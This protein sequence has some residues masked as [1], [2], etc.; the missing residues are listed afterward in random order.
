[1][2]RWLRVSRKAPCVSGVTLDARAFGRLG[3][4]AGVFSRVPRIDLRSGHF[5]SVVEGEGFFRQSDDVPPTVAEA[6]PGHIQGVV[7]FLRGPPP[8]VVDQPAEH[9]LV[10]VAELV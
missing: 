7:H 9:T 6:P 8:L 3:G 4:C 1:M 5:L 2:L 10:A